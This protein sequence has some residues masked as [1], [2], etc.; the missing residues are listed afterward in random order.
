VET[1]CRLQSIIKNMHQK[2][3]GYVTNVAELPEKSE[4]A[5]LPILFLNDQIQL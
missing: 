4:M 3:T 5:V 1:I 2:I